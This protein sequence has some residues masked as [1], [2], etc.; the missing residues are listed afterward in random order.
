MRSA[1]WKCPNCTPGAPDKDVLVFSQD[2]PR[3]FVLKC[4]AGGGIRPEEAAVGESWG[5]KVYL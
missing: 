2:Q 4:E 3:G 1:I 5:H